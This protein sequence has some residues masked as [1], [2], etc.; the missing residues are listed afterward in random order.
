MYSIK[1]ISMIFSFLG[2]FNELREMKK[3]GKVKNVWTTFG[4]RTEASSIYSFFM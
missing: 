1:N 2:F 3:V 4:I